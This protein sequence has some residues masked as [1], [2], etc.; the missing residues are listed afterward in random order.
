MMN[1]RF[2][3]TLTLALL[4][5]A[6]PA[7]ET[8]AGQPDPAKAQQIA[9]QVCA[10]C[11]GADGNSAIPVNP[12]LAAQIPE[13]TAKQLANFKGGQRA[14]AVMSGIAATLSAEDMA[15]LSDYY[16]GQAAKPGAAN[17]KE[18][19]LAGESLFRGGNPAN[20]LPACSGCHSPDGVGIPKQFPR[21]SGQ[22]A[23]YTIAQLRAFRS[24]ERANDANKMM[25][26]IAG[27]MSD[28][29]MQAVAEYISGLR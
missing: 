17:D 7:V 25:R 16:A 28:A 1:L 4:A 13:Y 8:Y 20:G 23:L 2:P 29:Q 5:V 6:C 26:M 22:H 19:A 3:C 27:R 24:G 14:N 9:T 10:A 18:L 21:L 12:N 11:H 15:S